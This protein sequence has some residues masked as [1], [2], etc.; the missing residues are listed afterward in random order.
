MTLYNFMGNGKTQ[1]D[2]LIASD[3]GV[4]LLLKRLEDS[5]K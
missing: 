2:T 1:T 5:L 3:V 4:V